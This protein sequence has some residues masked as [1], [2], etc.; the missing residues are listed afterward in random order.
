MLSPRQSKTTI[1]RH[2]KILEPF[3]N[4]GI[5]GFEIRIV[6]AQLPQFFW[7][8]VHPFVRKLYN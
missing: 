6:H 3:K 5:V 1:K 4:K 2:I 7:G 8:N